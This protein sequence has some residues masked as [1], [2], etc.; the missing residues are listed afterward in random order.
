M[1]FGMF[2]KKDPFCGMKEEKGKGINDKSGNWFCSDDC[3]KGYLN[4]I[5]QHNKDTKKVKSCCS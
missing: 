1:V 4:K 5:N 3:K 2:K